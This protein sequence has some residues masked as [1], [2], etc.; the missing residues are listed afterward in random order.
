MGDGIIALTS[1]IAIQRSARGESGY[2][3]FDEKWFDIHDDATPD[4]SD[5]KAE[6]DKL[7]N[8]KV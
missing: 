5:V 2:V 4:G 3:E 8:G 6:Y 7:V 1:N